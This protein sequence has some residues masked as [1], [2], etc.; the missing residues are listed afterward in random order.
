MVY[1]EVSSR[2]LETLKLG[3]ILMADSLYHQMN[4]HSMGNARIFNG[5]RLQNYAAISSFIAGVIPPMAML[6]RSL[7]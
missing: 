6:G 3:W 1:Y 4:C 5:V 2:T 7:L